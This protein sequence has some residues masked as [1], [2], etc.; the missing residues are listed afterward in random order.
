ME[1]IHDQP[2]SDPVATARKQNKIWSQAY[3]LGLA[4]QKKNKLLLLMWS[5]RSTNRN[6]NSRNIFHSFHLYGMAFSGELRSS[7]YASPS[8]IYALQR[9]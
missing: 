7:L 3:F 1:L 4:L 8:A 9:Q 6:R 5:E 2:P